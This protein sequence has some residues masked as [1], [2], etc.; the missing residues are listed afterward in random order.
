M[1]PMKCSKRIGYQWYPPVGCFEAHL[2][3]ELQHGH[4]QSTQSVFGPKSVPFKTIYHSAQRCSG[5]IVSNS[6]GSG[7]R[8]RVSLQLSLPLLE[9][10]LGRLSRGLHLVGVPCLGLHPL[11]R[12]L[13]AQRGIR[14]CD[15][16]TPT[17]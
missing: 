4:E 1:M 17:N 12:Y 15:T 5:S 16:D 9:F 8:G 7:Y 2:C 14:R 10:F 11:L 6:V 3:F 13:M